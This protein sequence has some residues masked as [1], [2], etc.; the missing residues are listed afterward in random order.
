MTVA[1]AR[2]SR[3]GEDSPFTTESAYV[4]ERSF[5]ERLGNVRS[6]LKRGS[7]STDSMW[8]TSSVKAGATVEDERVTR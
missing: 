6:A 1:F 7:P 5:M 4:G 3:T 8:P 2:F